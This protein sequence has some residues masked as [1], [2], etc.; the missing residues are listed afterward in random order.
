MDEEIQYLGTNCIE[1][2]PPD[3]ADTAQRPILGDLSIDHQSAPS[4]TDDGCGITGVVLFTAEDSAG[5]AD[6][7]SRVFF[8]TEGVT[9]DIGR[10]TSLEGERGDSATSGVVRATFSCPVMS[11]RHAVISFSDD[12]SVRIFPRSAH[13]CPPWADEAHSPCPHCR[14]ASLMSTHT[15]AR[16][17]SRREPQ[18]Q[19]RSVLRRGSLGCCAKAML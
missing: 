10:A 4:M 15:M 5:N 1:A 19:N 16:T 17:L 12:G 9:I 2:I 7:R 11:R 3:D 13:S 6:V 18:N 8:K 14:S